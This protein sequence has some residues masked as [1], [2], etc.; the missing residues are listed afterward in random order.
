MNL[1]IR[2]RFLQRL[3]TNRTCKSTT[4]LAWSVRA[5]FEGTLGWFG[6]NPTNLS[7]LSPQQCAE[8]T[9]KLAGGPDA[10][11]IAATQAAT[12]GDHQWA[13]ELSDHLIAAKK[14]SDEAKRIKVT[15]MRV[16]ADVEINAAARN[17]YLLSAHEMESSI[18]DN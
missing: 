18:N 14:H 13:L 2:W 12:N 7:R 17:Y 4:V 3:L 11:L 15:S 8:R 1:P 9:I 5:F 10:L 6:G 16:L